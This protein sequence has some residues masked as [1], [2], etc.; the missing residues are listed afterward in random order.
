MSD[1]PVTNQ[2]RIR[3]FSWMIAQT[4]GALTIDGPYVAGEA[5]TL[6]IADGRPALYLLDFAPLTSGYEAPYLGREYAAALR[7]RAGDFD[8]MA[9]PAY[10]GIPVAAL[11]C[12]AL[13]EDAIAKR[14][15]SRR[16]EPYG[17]ATRGL[18]GS[19][20]KDG[21]RLWLVDDVLSSGGSKLRE[22]EWYMNGD[23]HDR[24]LSITGATAMIDRQM[25]AMEGSRQLDVSG[26]GYLADQLGA[27]VDVLFTA[28][29]MMAV[30]HDDQ[31]EGPDGAVVITDDVMQ[32]FERYQ[33]EFGVSRS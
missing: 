11:T 18:V 16:K 28:S 31:V 24:E 22:R 27:P 26:R 13:A 32:A 10:T 23:V 17:D 9:V 4:P 20:L 29:Q 15:V 7:P 5:P 1:A 12:A 14:W 33:K 19:P 8:V 25:R 3:D 6:K 21:D 2:I 30:L